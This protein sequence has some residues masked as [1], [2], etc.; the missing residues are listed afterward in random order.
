MDMEG[1]TVSGGA[2]VFRLRLGRGAP[3]SLS[4]GEHA[5]GKHQGLRVRQGREEGSPEWTPGGLRE[6]G[7]PRPVGCLP[8]EDREAPR[9]NPEPGICFKIM[10]AEEGSR[11]VSS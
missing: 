7:R 10:G 6:A 9:R 8:V 1:P 4:R 5:L 11:W 2:Y 3:G